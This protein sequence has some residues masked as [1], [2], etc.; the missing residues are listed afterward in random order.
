MAGED[1]SIDSFCEHFHLGGAIL[2]KFA[3]HGFT[4]ARMLRFIKIEELKEMSFKFGE[5]AG[6][7]DAVETWSRPAK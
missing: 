1:M 3:E 2:G 6:L 4:W 5:I 7:K